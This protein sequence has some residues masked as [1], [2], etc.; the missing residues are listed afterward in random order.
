MPGGL[1]H[2]DAG[3]R[4]NL[5]TLGGGPDLMLCR[6]ES[7]RR[8]T[9]RRLHRRD[10]G[11]RRE[12]QRP[13]PAPISFAAP[14]TSPGTKSTVAIADFSELIRIDPK[15]GGAFANRGEAWRRKGE[16][17]LAIADLDRAIALRPRG[18]IAWFNRGITYSDKRR[19][20][21]RDRRLQPG[22]QAQFARCLVLQQPRQLLQRQRRLRQRPRRLQSG[23]R[24]Q[25]E[26]RTR[27][28]QPRHQ[29]AKT[30]HDTPAFADLNT[31]IRARPELRRRL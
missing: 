17:D 18:S 24:A 9:D 7:H 20:G 25:T 22:D 15:S 26:I 12:D 6:Q 30:G 11:E 10:R 5:L 13:S 2:G 21:S 19:S 31:S 23:D 4:A 16:L 28:F 29:L 1:V 8:P 14:T 27:L 3:F